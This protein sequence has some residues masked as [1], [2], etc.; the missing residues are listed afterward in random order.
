MKSKQQKLLFIIN[1]GSGSGDIDYKT[2]ITTFFKE[3]STTIET[4]ELP[5][6]CSLDQLNAAIKKA[7]AN[8]VIAVGG[9]GTLKLVAE[10]LVN[11][12]TPIGII[13]AG[14]ANGMAKELGIPLD[15]QEAIALT[16]AGKPKK[17]HVIMV[18]KE[19]CIHLSDIGFNAYIVKKFDELPERGMLT[20]AKA[21]WH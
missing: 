1:P 10:C 7:K 15:L 8:R 12:E 4:Y 16:I 18:N 14:S 11:T 3:Q 9:D 5:I 21:A 17:I 20:Y 19:L 6:S 13:P 2:E